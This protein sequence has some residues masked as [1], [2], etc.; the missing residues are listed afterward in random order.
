MA[1]LKAKLAAGSL[2]LASIFSPVSLADD[3]SVSSPAASSDLF[4]P[5]PLREEASCESLFVD[6]EGFEH[7]PGVSSYKYSVDYP[8]AIGISIYPGGDLNGFTPEEIGTIFVN[9]FRNQGLHAECFVS[10]EPVDGGTSINFNIRGQSWEEDGSMNL[11]AAMDVET[12][13]SVVAE[14]KT[15]NLILASSGVDF[16]PLN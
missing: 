3:R 9:T 11:E 7:G 10:A 4:E 6:N 13:R 12:L 15:G 8:G 16:T 14:A 2:V 5:I 1:G